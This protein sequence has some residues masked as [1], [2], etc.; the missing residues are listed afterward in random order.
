MVLM[1]ND[2]HEFMTQDI[3]I[4]LDE[5]DHLT[6]STDTRYSLDEVVERIK[7]GINQHA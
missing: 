6:A 4:R 7:E 2:Q 3:E 1:S 5:A